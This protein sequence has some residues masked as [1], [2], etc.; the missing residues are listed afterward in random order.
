MCG[1]DPANLPSL[2]VRADLAPMVKLSGT[3][4]VNVFLCSRLSFVGNRLQP[5]GPPLS[6]RGQIQTAVDQG[7][8]DAETRRTTCSQMRGAQAGTP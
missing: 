3:P 2:H 4:A 1:A 6:P 8:A 5:P 7:R